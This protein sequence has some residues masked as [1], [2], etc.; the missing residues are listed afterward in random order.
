MIAR[1][2]SS[3]QALVDRFVRAQAEGDLSADIDAAGLTRYLYALVQGM[4]VQAS[5]GATR[6]EMEQLVDLCMRLWPSR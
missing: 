5:S 1:R 2:L 6:A 4:A 3:Q